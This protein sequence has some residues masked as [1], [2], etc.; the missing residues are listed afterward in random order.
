MSENALLIEFEKHLVRKAPA[1]ADVLAVPYSTYA[2]YRNNTHKLPAHL[3]AHIDVIRRLPLDRLHQLIK[4][5]L[6]DGA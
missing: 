6:A 5:R 3:E 2:Q 4:D 1:A